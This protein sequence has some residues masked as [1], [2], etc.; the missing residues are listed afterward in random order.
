M[1]SRPALPLDTLYMTYN[2]VMIKANINEVKA[3]FSSYVRRARA[4]ET[5]IVCERNIPVAELRQ[6]ETDKHKKEVVLGSMKG[7]IW[8]A[9]DAFDPMTEGELAEWYDAPLSTGDE[10][11]P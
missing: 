6:I 11:Q 1:Q 8:V 2:K 10:I 4:G 3:H 9:D 7:M 5:V